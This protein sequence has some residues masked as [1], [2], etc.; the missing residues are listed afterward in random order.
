L[1]NI[2]CWWL[3]FRR[4]EKKGKR[5]KRSKERGKKKGGGRGKEGRV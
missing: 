3:S 2:W 1:A 4:I 5:G